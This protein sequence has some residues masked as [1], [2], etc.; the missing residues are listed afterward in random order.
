MQPLEALAWIKSNQVGFVSK[1]RRA[2]AFQEARRQVQTLF[3]MLDAWQEVRKMTINQ[4]KELWSGLA[5]AITRKA[6]AMERTVADIERHQALCRELQA[7]TS[8][9][10]QERICQEIE[11]LAQPEKYL[12]FSGR[13]PEEQQQFLAASA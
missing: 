5:A 6:A 4:M 10:D 9:A 1:Q 8:L 13:T 11:S 7:C 12:A 3:P 2:E